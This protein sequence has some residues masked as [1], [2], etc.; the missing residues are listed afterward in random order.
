MITLHSSNRLE[1]LASV[2][3]E[4][5]R[6]GGGDPLR[7]A[8]IAVPSNGMARWLALRLADDNRIA[9]NL[10]F[11]LPGTLIWQVFHAVLPER[12]PLDTS[13]F[14]AEALTWR[15]FAYFQGGEAIEAA[16]DD[17]L[18]QADE[19]ARFELAR[20]LADVFDQ[21][22]IYRPDWIEAWEAGEADHWQARLWRRLVA[23]QGGGPHRGH[24][25]AELRQ[26]LPWDLSEPA[27]AVEGFADR[28][29]VFGLSSIPPA[30][31]DVLA[32]L[33]RWVPVAVYRL[34]PT[35]EYG[36][37]LVTPATAAERALADTADAPYLE[38]GHP[39]LASWG[40]QGA[41]LENLLQE[42]DPDPRDHFADP[43]T[44]SVLATLQSDIL[45]LRQRE[46]PE[47]PDAHTAPEPAEAN[48]AFDACHSPMR[49]VEVLY[50]RLLALFQDHPD[51]RPGD[52]L[53]M[54]PDIDTYAPYIEAVFGHADDRPTIP[55]KIADRGARARSSMVEAAFRLLELPDGRFGANE[56][57]DLLALPPVL[58]RAGLT[59]AERDRIRDWV[60]ETG[61]RWGID[62]AF[63]AEH[64]LPE[65]ASHTWKAG[66]DRQLLGYALPGNGRTLFG[67]ILPYPEAEGGWALT[68]GRFQAFVRDLFRWRPALQEARTPG[69]WAS[70]LQ[71]YL[72]RF[73]GEAAPE[74]TDEL[75]GIHRGLA[76]TAQLAEGAGFGEP[77]PR[78]VMVRELEG[79]LELSAE[80]RSFLGHGVTFCAMTPMRAIPREAIFLLGMNDGAFPRIKRP[81]AFD[82]M[83]SD[84]RPGDRARREDDRYLFLE[85]LLS[86]RRHLGISYVGADI[87]ANSPRPPSV[88][89]S[90]LAEA[91][92]AAFPSPE[93]GPTCSER[94]TARHPLH[95]F[96][97]R[98]F[99][100]EEPGLFSYSSDLRES[101]ENLAKPDHKGEPPAFFD[102]PLPEPD[103]SWRS[104]ELEEVIAFFR[105][106]ARFLLRQ[107]MGIRL[108][109]GE[110]ELAEREPFQLDGLERHQ[111]RQHVFDHWWAGREIADA[112]PSARA[113]GLLPHGEAG[114]AVVTQARQ[115]VERFAEQLTPERAEAFLDPVPV[116]LAMGPIETAGWLAHL[117][118]GGQLLYRCGRIN[119]RMAVEG[120]LRHLALCTAAPEAAEH[121]TRILGLD[122]DVHL[123]PIP[124][125]EAG[126][127]LAELG[128]ALWNG[129]QAPLP[130][131]PRSAL[132]Y[133]QSLANKGDRAKALD[134]AAKEWPSN[135]YRS[136]P[137]ECEDPYNAL[138]FGDSGPAERDPEA[139]ADLAERLLGPIGGQ[140]E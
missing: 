83:A 98:Y 90:E 41:E 55:F 26:R 43:G 12:R 19:L 4:R 94:L 40:R 133:A 32:R 45:N 28:L 69:E 23:D 102:R 30:Y 96:S 136:R 29:H 140:L 118:P 8:R 58:A 36:A 88:L 127:T 52:V 44:G 65:E 110:E 134:A 95:A 24:L 27:G 86:A 3:A 17:Y 74:D 112:E 100:G 109:V 115:E 9:A 6:E 111:L 13:A 123:D 1:D 75:A 61:I 34:A 104:L 14:A 21:Y 107:R 66:L 67:G 50:D 132:T 62:A 46:G 64:G 108:D 63:R 84:Y 53:V 54:T 139:F 79:H 7:P 78:E 20:R 22:L 59:E 116:R 37:D 72:E 15:L 18:Q 2:L 93:G 119:E 101:A 33:S 113:A 125:E 70:L 120:M 73:L 38:T 117:Q 124:A 91:I 31:L 103:E 81:Q 68:L 11:P 89:V 92:D 122:T 60:S 48:V 49:E 10:D 57:L 99:T 121:Q 97:P 47:G 135:E 130:F 51:L 114:E 138:A 71:A 131:L 82:R 35:Q 25:L 137:S 42:M 5:L 106:P 39:L 80:G 76:R 105:Q 126:E 85:T 128:R 16:I 129:L 56:V 77:I 87:R